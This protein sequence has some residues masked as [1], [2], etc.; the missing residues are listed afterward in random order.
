MNVLTARLGV[1]S[2]SALALLLPS[3][4]GRT[5]GTVPAHRAGSAAMAEKV[6]SVSPALIAAPPMVHTPLQTAR[7]MTSL[8]RPS[9]DI[10]PVGFTQLPG[11]GVF[12]AASQDGSVWVLSTQGSGPDRPIFHYVNGTWTNVPGAAMRLAVGPDNT[13]WAVNSAGGIYSYKNGAWSTIAGGA[14]DI[15]VGADGSVYVISSVTGNQYGN[16][17]W[18]YAGGT[19]TQLPGSGV[20]IASSWDAGTYNYNVA[21]GGFYIINAQQSIFYYNTST[22]FTQIPGAAVQLAPTTNGGLFVLGTPPSSNGT[23]V[24]YNNLATGTWTQQNG[25]GTTIATN[26]TN[27]YV[28]GAAGG[29]YQAAVRPPS[30]TVFDYPIPTAN[31]GPYGITLGPDGNMWFTESNTNTNKVGKIT[32]GGI[33]TDYQAPT[34]NAFPGDIVSVGGTLW[35]ADESAHLTSVTTGGT[36]TQ[37]AAADPSGMT[38]GPDG[39]IWVLEFNG[40]QVDVYS[41][42]GTLL[43]TYAAN[44]TPANLQLEE[45]ITGPDGNMWF[46][47]FS[48][49]N[50]VKMITS[51]GAT[52]TY[53]LSGTFSGTLRGIAAGNDGNLWICDEDDDKIIRVT[54]AGV[55]TGF[56]VPTAN[57]QPYGITNGGDGYLYFTEPGTNQTVYKIGR[58][59]TTGAITEFPIPTAYAGPTQITAGPN[60]TIWFTEGARARSACC[61]REAAVGARSATWWAIMDSNH[62]PHAYQACALT[63]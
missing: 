40:H 20:R 43:H 59:S 16:G 10:T 32:P 11:A 26:S 27:L 61:T 55:A 2:L 29:I 30:G 41:T 37:H 34:T 7:A 1:V 9:S 4:S 63:N 28:T 5:T 39:N 45:I 19:W 6:T 57:A 25:L 52:T 58:I 17:I 3:C 36:F 12:V 49:D 21:P 35:Y 22:G 56:T 47:T 53:N 38:V 18:H 33:I 50:V 24:Y 62:G 13:L 31:S 15:A 8:R 23:Q 60:H 14:N 46:D 54:T 42:A 48:G 44:T 51:T